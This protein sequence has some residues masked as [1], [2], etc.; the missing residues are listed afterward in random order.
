MKGLDDGP[1]G[2]NDAA[3]NRALGIRKPTISRFHV[4]KSTRKVDIYGMTP[5]VVVDRSD[6]DRILSA[7]VSRS[8]ARTEAERMLTASIE[9]EVS[10]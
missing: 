1:D 3:F 7:H 4:R 10:P 5:W 2:L 9:D 8:D 6:C